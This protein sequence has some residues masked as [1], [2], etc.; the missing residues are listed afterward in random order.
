MK[1]KLLLIIV[2]AVSSLCCRAEWVPDFE[3]DSLG[4]CLI[5]L[6]DKTVSVG[7]SQS[8]KTPTNV[9]IPP[10]VTFMDSEWTVT[11]IGTSGFYSTQIK[12]VDIPN[13]E[14]EIGS[15]AFNDTPLT[16]ITIP[17][18]VILIGQAAFQSTRLD[19]I[20]I[21]NSV[22]DFSSAVFADCRSLKSATIG[23][24]VK[25]IL[26]TFRNCTSLTTIVLGSSINYIANP[27][28]QN[29]KALASIT[30][31]STTPPSVYGQGFELITYL[32][33]AL[34]VP[35]GSEEAYRTTAP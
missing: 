19:S 29:C 21:P 3:I 30:C 28:F 10:K 23:D 1:Q 20:T 13:S 16:S 34:I 7:K 24:S 17:N 26:A 22:T 4:Y 32:T 12:S 33:A 18:S 6:E 5:S 31:K 27:A 9:V 14:T 15:Y 25:R 8:Q 35:D 11:A 2:L